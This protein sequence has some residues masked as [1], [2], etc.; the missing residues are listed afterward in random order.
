MGN[1]I[2]GENVLNIKN[3]SFSDYSSYS[4]KGSKLNYDNGFF[5]F[6][7]SGVVGK[8][9]KVFDWL[10]F[11][12]IA[13][14]CMLAYCH[15][16]ILHTASSSFSYLTGHFF[17]FYDYNVAKQVEPM[18][19]YM[20]STYLL[21]AIWNLPL[22]LLGI[23]RVPWGGSPFVALMWYK[24][25]PIVFFLGCG[26]VLYR[27]G[28][29]IG[30]GEKKSK[31]LTYVFLTCPIAFF[32]PFI[33]GQYDSFTTFFI[34]M[35]LFYYLKN[36][37]FKFVL[38]FSI[39]ITFKYFA[40]LIFLPL[41]LLKEKNIFI[42]FK[43][44]IM[45]AVPFLFECL[46]YLKS[47]MF[48]KGVFNFAVK[49]NLFTASINL[50][51]VSFSWFLVFWV[52]LLGWAYYTETSA[53]TRTEF[54]NW[55]LY[56]SNFIICLV[57]AICV[58]H[59]QWLLIAM[60]FVILSTFLNKNPRIFLLIEIFMFAVF[61]IYSAQAWLDGVD[62]HMLAKGIFKKLM[63]PIDSDYGVPLSMSSFL[64]FGGVNFN[65]SLL[66]GLFIFNLIFKHPKFC[67]EKIDCSFEKIVS[68]WN[69]VRVRL[70]SIVG[71][72][73]VPTL[74]C[75]IVSMFSPFFILKNSRSFRGEVFGVGLKNVNVNQIYVPNE[76]F[77]ISQFQLLLIKSGEIP[78]EVNRNTKVDTGKIV[79]SMFREEDGKNLFNKTF[80]VKL[81]TTRPGPVTCK[82][83]NTKL[84]AGKRY[85]ISV[86]LSDELGR[87]V[88]YIGKTFGGFDESNHAE[89]DGHMQGY[90]YCIDVL[91][92]RA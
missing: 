58:W 43:R 85:K 12:L 61:V 6:F 62:Q 42:I 32:G 77:E 65:F 14:F 92:K 63:S 38:F 30:F 86:N 29:L 91:G 1:A 2:A 17:D 37:D 51:F 59:P 68:C 55:A 34:L 15:Q 9:L 66:S 22:F 84:E 64:H 20:P 79:I 3:G 89:I 5:S 8:P 10:A 88:A 40:L 83:E 73:V 33:M 56:F 76:N 75:L 74:F 4:D 7:K 26:L 11:L 78:I 87:S 54:V 36:D 82:I 28:I 67:V 13:V 70:F 25:L 23:K 44:C 41:L 90:S 80:D 47:P 45:L 21:F 52:V 27:I 57:F 53:M 72:W 35:G 50:G 71:F 31:I 39:A 60:P 69:M 46:F 24:L 18:N 49:D 81:P 16:D 19:N 48:H